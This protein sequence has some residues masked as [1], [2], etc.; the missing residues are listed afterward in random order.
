M[1][2]LLDTTMPVYIDGKP[3][4]FVPALTNHEL[5]YP[6]TFLD[7]E[8]KPHKVN[9]KGILLGSTTKKAEN[10]SRKIIYFTVNVW[11]SEFGQKLSIEHGQLITWNSAAEADGNPPV[12]PDSVLFSS[13][14]K[15]LKRTSYSTEI[16]VP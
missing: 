1:E 9:I 7:H 2:N 14:W 15:L 11:G 10:K 12:K 5:D 13:P 16:T 3:A 4:Y 8:L 6:Y